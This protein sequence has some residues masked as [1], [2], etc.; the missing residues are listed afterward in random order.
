VAGLIPEILVL[1]DSLQP[2][3]CNVTEA[4]HCPFELKLCVLAH[5]HV[6]LRFGQHVLRA[7][8][9]DNL[10]LSKQLSSLSFQSCAAGHRNDYEAALLGNASSLCIAC[11]PGFSTVNGSNQPACTACLPGSFSEAEGSA[12]CTPCAAGSFADEVGVTA[13][14]ACSLNSWQHHRGQDRCDVCDLGT[15]IHYDDALEAAGSNP[16]SA[17]TAADCLPCPFRARCSANGSIDAE[18][19]AYLLLEQE[20]GT[21]RS[22]PCSPTACSLDRTGAS[23]EYTAGAERSAPQ[24]TW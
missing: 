8:T 22:V 9:S 12:Q 3:N 14:S 7:A 19:G 6:Y 18:G 4:T 2:L 15:Y 23:R 20:S 24:R 1:L 5:C 21:V 16:S 13:C 17:R 10:A 11:P